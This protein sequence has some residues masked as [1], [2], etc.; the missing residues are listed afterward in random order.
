MKV[1]TVAI[2]VRY[3]QDAVSS[4]AASSLVEVLS[5]EHEIHLLESSFKS[6]ETD[7]LKVVHDFR[8]RQ[9]EEE[10]EFGNYVE[11]LLSQPFVGPEIQEHGVQWLKS[12]IKIEKY[13]KTEI[14]AAKIIADYAMKVVAEDPEKTDFFLAGP[15]TM[16]RIRVFS[17]GA[18]EQ[19]RSRRRKSPKKQ[20]AA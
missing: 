5:D 1:A 11:E 12:K 9:S 8:Q 14:D 15:S 20:V 2:V 6:G 7:P 18:A 17:L 3:P 13:Q 16:V 10:G 4:A 19:E